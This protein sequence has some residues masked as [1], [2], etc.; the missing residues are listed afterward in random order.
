MVK[1]KPESSSHATELVPDV[2]VLPYPTSPG[3]AEIPSNFDE[4]ELQ[5]AHQSS[6]EDGPS[7]QHVWASGALGGIESIPASLRAG[8]EKH[9]EHVHNVEDIP[10]SLRVGTPG[11]TPRSSSE[12]EKPTMRSTNPYIRRQ[13]TGQSTCSDERDGSANGWGESSERPP[14]PLDTPPLLPIP[15]GEHLACLSIEL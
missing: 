3:T 15:K 12:M 8:G 5:K 10:E 6:A 13:Q 7:S 11:L 4:W 14:Q 2:S 1:R 9:A